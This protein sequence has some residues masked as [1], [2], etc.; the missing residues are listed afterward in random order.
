MSRKKPLGLPDHDQFDGH[1]ERAR[2]VPSGRNN[3]KSKARHL[4]LAE[5][6]R[7]LQKQGWL[8]DQDQHVQETILHRVALKRFPAG[9]PIFSTGDFGGGIYG[10]AKG[11]LGV[12]VPQR[13]GHDR[14][15]TVIRPGIW[16]GY[17]PILTRRN[18]TLTF[19]AIEPS[20]GLQVPL[21]ILDQL[22]ASD[23]RIFR[24]LTGLSEYGMDQAIAICADNL[25]PNVDRRL[26]ATLLR[27]APAEAAGPDG[28]LIISGLTQAQIAEMANT[29]RDIANRV[30]K[31]FEVKGWIRVSYRQITILDQAALTRFCS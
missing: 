28:S 5:A 13:N 4:D 1:L 3:P 19:A 24:A 9:S 10:L 16:F 8:A 17:G 26:A 27:I 14:L 31:R 11:A 23:I 21:G 6:K 22:A 2:P 12:Y 20:L 25:I 30:L 29:A 7:A 15:A 18:R